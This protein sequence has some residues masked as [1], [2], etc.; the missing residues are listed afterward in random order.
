[1]FAGT[2]QVRVRGNVVPVSLFGAFHIVCSILRSL[3]LA[4]RI[5]FDPD[6]YDVIFVDQQSAS[7]PLLRLG[8]AKIFFYC[9]FPDKLLTRR[10]SL[11]KRIYRWPLDMLEEYTTG[12]PRTAPCLLLQ[13]F[14]YTLA[15]PIFEISDNA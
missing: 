13:K 5:L 9:H 6:D 3:H 11:L 2:L 15:M 12:T 10:D 7:I 1:M 8:K 4:I 14:S